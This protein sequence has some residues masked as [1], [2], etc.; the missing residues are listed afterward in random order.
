MRRP[1]MYL[2]GLLLAT[3]AS[4]ALAGPAAAATDGHKCHHGNHYYN[5]G[6][7]DDEDWF[8]YNHQFQYNHNSGNTVNGIALLN[9]WGDSSG[10]IPIF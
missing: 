1:V 5:N 3:G 8:Y 6:W 4:L 7:D 10:L 9:H 2:A